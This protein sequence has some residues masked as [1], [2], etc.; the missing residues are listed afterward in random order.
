MGGFTSNSKQWVAQESKVLDRAER[1]IVQVILHRGTM[2][3][4]VLSGDLIESGR[5]EYNPKGG[6]SVVFGNQN[7]PY[8]RIHELG[9][10]TGRNY[11]TNIRAKH[12]LKTAGDSVVKENIKKYV[13]LS[14]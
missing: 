14:R 1:A 12:Y 8:A 6:R 9:G 13:D 4:P 5:V 7:V 2:L 11:K 10:V 3:A